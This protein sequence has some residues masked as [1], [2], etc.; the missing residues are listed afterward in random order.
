[1]DAEAGDLV[2]QVRTDALLQTA[3]IITIIRVVITCPL[4]FLFF[5]FF[6]DFSQ[7]DGGYCLTFDQGQKLYRDLSCWRHNRRI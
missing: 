2:L 7:H 5:L 4:F 6:G 1:M 3:N